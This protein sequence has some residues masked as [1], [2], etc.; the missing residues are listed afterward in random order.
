MKIKRN[1]YLVCCCM[2]IALFEKKKK[3]Q[4]V[5]TIRELEL[6]IYI[7]CHYSV[8]CDNPTYISIA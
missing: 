6:L 1:I 7:C 2:D 4:A 5:V 3:S 8:D